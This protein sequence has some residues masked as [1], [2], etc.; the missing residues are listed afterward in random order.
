MAELLLDDGLENVEEEAVVVGEF[1]T[2]GASGDEITKGS[3]AL[4]RGE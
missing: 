2:S 1:G 3:K 4:P